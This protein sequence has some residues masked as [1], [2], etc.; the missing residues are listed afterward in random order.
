MKL[1]Q[2]KCPD[3]DVLFEYNETAEIY[4]SEDAENL[5]TV[6]QLEKMLEEGKVKF[7][8]DDVLIEAKKAAKESDDE[9]DEDEGTDDDEAVDESADEDEEDHEE[10]D[11]DECDENI[12]NFGDKKAEPFKK[13]DDDE[14]EESCDDDDKHKEESLEL[15]YTS[16]ISEADR[17]AL[18]EGEELSEEYQAKTIT[19]F[20]AA[21]SAKVKE[22]SEEIKAHH[23]VS[24]DKKVAKLEESLQNQVNDY[25]DY[26]VT[27]WMQE[28]EIAIEN[29]LKNDMNENFL[30][31]LKGLF[32]EHFIEIPENRY[33]I[34]EGL[35]DKVE[36]LEE[37]LD[38]Q[39]ES[40]AS[41]L[42]ENKGQTRDKIIVKL[43]EGLSDNQKEKF[44]SLVE[45]V[46]SDDLEE[47]ETKALSLKESYFKVADPAKETGD[48]INES[49]HDT[50]NVVNSSEWD[51]LIAKA[52]G[53]K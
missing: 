9:D 30:N 19:I 16:T 14:V 51:A 33:D 27:E 15:D 42:A 1:K 3:T 25:L 8:E 50:S 17:S 53:L 37:Q 12:K 26:V 52:S 31:G 5:M 4:V 11:G 13:G 49:E 18:F 24:A 36:S 48:S 7:N 2:F 32:S 38:K 23:K 22:L 20:E 34:L 40:N 6:E 47:F 39:L 35:A 46:A 10:P 45:H 21:V 29:G 43:S 44:A 28:N 41:L